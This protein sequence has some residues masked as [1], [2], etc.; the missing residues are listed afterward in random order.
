V[1]AREAAEAALSDALDARSAAEA[2]LSAWQA[3][4]EALS[5]AL[6]EARARAGQERLSGVDGVVGTLL[7][8]VEIDDGW[9]AAFEAAAGEAVA[10]V[11]LR[12]VDSA[13][14]AL[15]L[16]REG[17]FSGSVLALGTVASSTPR[18]A[19]AGELRGHVRAAP[20]VDDTAAVERL[21]DALVGGVE[22]AQSWSEALDVVLADPHAVAVTRDGDRFGAA[23]WRLGASGGTGA[24]GAA[25]DEARSRTEQ[26]ATALDEARRA[27]SA[28]RS[29]A[30]AARSAESEAARERDRTVSA[31]DA[32]QSAL[33]RVEAQ[34]LDAGNEAGSLRAHTAE[35]AT[36]GDRDAKRLADLESLL[37]TLEAAEAEAAEAARVMST[38]RERLDER[39]AALGVLRRDL[40]VRV[41]GLEERR[42]FL[43]GRRGE[44]EARLSASI[45]ARQEAHARRVA[46]E[47]REAVTERLAGYVAARRAEIERDLAELRARRQ[48]QSDAA[49]AVSAELNAARAERGRLTEELEASRELLRRAELDEAET[50]LRLEQAVETL[51]HDLDS[52]PGV[53]MAAPA[54]EL[55]EG[56]SAAAR[57]RD[58]ERDL[59]LMGP[60]NPLALEEFEAQQ[61][62]QRFIEGQL[63]D[64]KVS[65]RELNKVIR[66]VD[67]EIMNVFSSAYADVE[68]NFRQ[69]FDTLFP[70]GKGRLRLT[71]PDNLLETGI[72]V[73]ARPSG[74]NVRKLSLLSGGERSL[75]AL[76]FLFAVFRARPSPFY[77]MDEVEAALDDVNL[78]RFLDLLQEFR[79]EAQLIVVSHQKRTMEAADCLYGVTMKPG[80]SSRVVSEKA[81]TAAS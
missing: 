3:R 30:D 16:L 49:R 14:R 23:G 80:G 31:L 1:A 52:E 43:D 18:G 15:R 69:L 45:D 37:P 68:A 32:A 39:G 41:R 17:S 78:H 51:R 60:I 36:Q 46:L 64:V 25:L 73:E 34:R 28:A 10:A 21:L 77:V 44:V 71:E 5:Q 8:V 7:D 67:A 22:V 19:T 81:A 35:L 42:D 13:R 55:P 9:Q 50:R 59:R 24:T 65:R 74:K 63:D 38:E 76:A 75:T 62:R 26:A 2:A 6:A 61:E 29:A 70:G 33:Q 47:R 48:R 4:S 57:V 72:E 79:A 58:L 56:T 66:A 20:R 54:P 53:A 27:E 40:E 12:G 11:V